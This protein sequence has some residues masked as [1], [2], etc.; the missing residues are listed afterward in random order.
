MKTIITFFF[1]PIFCLLR[2]FCKEKIAFYKDEYNW[3]KWKNIKYSRLNVCRFLITDKAV[4]NLFYYRLGP[5]HRL[6]SWILPGYDH[7]QIPTIRHQIGG[8]LIIQHG[9]ATIISAQSIGHNCKIYQQVTIGYNHK[10]EAPIIGDNVEI[11][12]GAKII[13]GIK[14]GNNV[15]IGSNSVVITD[16]PDNCVVAGIPARII[17]KLPEGTDIFNRVQL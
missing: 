4:R 11:C 7:L 12:C 2:I 10:L 1:L 8:G 14:I 16:I 6:L 17:R 13:G 15:L 5:L 9:F 3:C